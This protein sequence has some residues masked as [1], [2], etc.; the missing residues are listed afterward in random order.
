MEKK[1]AVC[2]VVA[3]IGVAACAP[4]VPSLPPSPPSGTNAGQEAARY[5][6]VR[7]ETWLHVTRDEGAHRFRAAS[8]RSVRDALL[9]RHVRIIAGADDWVELETGFDAPCADA[10][11]PG[12]A[13]RLHA[14][15]SGFS[16]VVRR[17]IDIEHGDGT[18]VHLD[19]GMMA[20]APSSGSSGFTYVGDAY[21][22]WLLNLVLP[23][24]HIGATNDPSPA[25]EPRP[26][27]DWQ[28]AEGALLSVTGALVTRKWQGTQQVTPVETRGDSTLVEIG[29]RCGWFRALVPTDQLRQTVPGGIQ[30][31]V[32]VPGPHLRAGAA[33]SWPDGTPAGK[34]L[35]TY[36][37]A[38]LEGTGERRCMTESIATGAETA[39]GRVTLCFAA[40]DLIEEH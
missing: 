21:G 3:W 33:L 24:D 8:E 19:P 12:L 2:C 39:E 14:S 16:G 34:T 11:L 7:A 1:S 25:P 40:T 27:G 20:I 37:P 36:H 35:R 30:G 31:G 10:L 17:P 28:V 5:A 29:G 18:A 4:A 26:D 22:G 32:V 23:S 13:I 6:S 38:S 9:P 15:A